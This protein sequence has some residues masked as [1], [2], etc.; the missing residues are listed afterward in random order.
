M[1]LRSQ[2]ILVAVCLFLV[3]SLRADPE[4][5]MIE[6]LTF[7]RP[8]DWEWIVPEAEARKAHLRIFNPNKTK[9]ADAI[10]YWFAP[11]DKQADPEGCVKRWQAQFKNKDDVLATMERNTFGKYKVTY[12]QMEGT[13]KGFGKEATSLPDYALLGTVVQSDRGSIMVRMTGPKD[14]VHNSMKPF[15]KMIEDALKEE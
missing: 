8:K 13:Y 4:N 9:S 12:A 15:K 7:I 14:L 3:S 10:F 5:F 2:F 6:D 1:K 11:E